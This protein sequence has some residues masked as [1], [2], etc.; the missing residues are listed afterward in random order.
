MFKTRENGFP[1]LDGEHIALDFLGVSL[2]DEGIHWSHAMDAGYVF[3][4]V[5][6][7]LILASVGILLLRLKD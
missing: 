6:I 5:G 7:L 2:N 3:L 1:L 4:V